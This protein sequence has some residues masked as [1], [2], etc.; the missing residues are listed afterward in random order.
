[1]LE[2]G[3]P[4]RSEGI[5]LNQLLFTTNEKS[6]RLRRVTSLLTKSLVYRDDNWN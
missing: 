1:M 2:T 6:I 4:L 3:N 5:P